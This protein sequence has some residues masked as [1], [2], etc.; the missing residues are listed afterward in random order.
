MSLHLSQALT[1]RMNLE[2]SLEQRL[3]VK[4]SLKLAL[5][6][7]LKRE[8]E[9]KKLY[10]K[11]LR[12]GKVYRYKRYGMEFEFACVSVK[13]TPPEIYKHSGHAFSHC[14][15]N[16]WEAFFGGIKF[17]LSRGSWLLFVIED[18]YGEPLPQAC[19]DYAAV[20]ERG[21]QVTLGDHNLASKLEFAIAAKEQK[22]RWYMEWTEATCPVKF[23]DVFTYQV[24]VE[25]P[26]GEEAAELDAC[27]EVFQASAEA[28]AVRSMMEEF[29]WPMSL[30]R[31]L[32]LY[33]EA[34][35]T[36]AGHVTR[37]FESCSV[38]VSG[39]ST[40]IGIING[41]IGELLTKEL[42][43]IATGELRRCLSIPRL[44]TV[45][46]QGYR[47]LSAVHAEMVIK[48]GELVGMLAFADELKDLE[49]GGSLPN[50]GVFSPHFE[51]AL[52]WVS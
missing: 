43:K 6:L 17:A 44:S 13:D 8:D 49:N 52:K 39:A 11:A 16:P 10:A 3:S 7:Y 23:A 45:W 12:L 4:Q 35:D 27:L 19:I 30:L 28:Q 29:E 31:K 46:E 22:L 41:K 20:H 42:T 26:Q 14:L 1:Q 5:K 47:Q 25:L 24:H 40:P 15:F 33:A 2:Q 34:N 50:R 18:M 9:I 37:M 36:M 51:E 32:E 38:V 21:E 48:R